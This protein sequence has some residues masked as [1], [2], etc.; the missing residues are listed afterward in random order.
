L[1]VDLVTYTSL[2]GANAALAPLS[3]EFALIH[4][5]PHVFP[6]YE[7]VPLGPRRTRMD[8]GIGAIFLDMDG[9]TTLTED[10]CLLALEDTMREITLRPAREQWAGLDHATD[11]PNIIGSSTS[12]N[13]E[14]LL[15]V[16]GPCIDDAAFRASYVRA[17]ALTLAEAPDAAR[18][19]EVR[20]EL[21]AL[22]VP[23]LELA[24]EIAALPA[25]ATG[26]AQGPAPEVPGLAARFAPRLDL[27]PLGNRIRAG[28]SIYYERLH[29][30]FVRIQ[31]GR[32]REV[33]EE[34]YGPGATHAI[35][36]LHGVGVLHALAKGWLGEEA[37]AL[38]DLL[39]HATGHVPGAQETLARLGKAFAQAPARVA[40]VTSSGDFE[41]DIVLK[42]VFA[43]LCEEAAA[44]PVSAPVRERA[45]R[46]FASYRAFYDTIV[47][48][49][50]SHEIRL[51]PYRDLYSIALHNIGIPCEEAH[52][53]LGFEDTEAGIVAQRSAGLGV[54]CAVPF[55]GSRGH[56]FQAASHVLHGGVPEAILRH[57][58][59]L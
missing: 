13:I 4:N 23:D 11:Y 3:N 41:A 48:A 14:Y 6:A 34:L 1:K 39:M 27:A 58:L 25:Y 56:D 45:V 31:L 55:E 43:G 16:Y 17:V 12:K 38:A 29:G 22:G 32:G 42:E 54:C 9:T 15:S 44:W 36:P 53:V 37:A 51:K 46:G 10:L 26:R 21:A 40:L 30:M 35:R 7:T 24:P 8:D 28:M 20:A 59:F 5:A 47:T 18:L 49:S 33:A 50:N 52:R 57:G 19:H 2:A